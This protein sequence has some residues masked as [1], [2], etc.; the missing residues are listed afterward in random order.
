MNNAGNWL[1]GAFGQNQTILGLK[2][3]LVGSYHP[4]PYLPKSDYFRIEIQGYEYDCIVTHRQNQTILGLKYEYHPNSQN[5]SPCQN[6]TILGLKYAMDL[7]GYDSE[8]SQNQTI[9][10]LKST[11]V[12]GY[13]FP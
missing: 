6:Q 5:T 10:G 13:L 7:E 11:F 12:H 3:G 2:W 1:K 4:L 8:A 9:L